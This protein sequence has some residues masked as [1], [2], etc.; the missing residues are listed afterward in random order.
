MLVAV[1][2]RVVEPAPA[3]VSVVVL[4]MIAGVL[5]GM[6]HGEWRSLALSDWSPKPIKTFIDANM[7]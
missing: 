6:T 3:V 5:L 4:A 1:L 2:A 7:L